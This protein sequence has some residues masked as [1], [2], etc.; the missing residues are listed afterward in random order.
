[1]KAGEVGEVG[2]KSVP[3]PSKL[4]RAAST[5]S[6]RR[7]K[8]RT[9]KMTKSMNTDPASASGDFQT[10]PPESFGAFDGAEPKSDE[11][12][13]AGVSWIEDDNNQDD[14][15]SRQLTDD[16]ISRH[17]QGIGYVDD[18]DESEDDEE[19]TLHRS[20]SRSRVSRQHSRSRGSSSDHGSSAAPPINKSFDLDITAMSSDFDV[21]EAR[22]VPGRMSIVSKANTLQV[23][24]Q[25]ENQTI[26][27]FIAVDARTQDLG[28]LAYELAKTA[29]LVADGSG[30][31][32][33]FACDGWQLSGGGMNTDV[34][35]FMESDLR[36]ETRGGSLDLG[37]KLISVGKKYALFFDPG[38]ENGDYKD[39]VI[40]GTSNFLIQGRKDGVGAAEIIA[41][42]VDTVILKDQSGASVAS[43]TTDGM[44]DAERTLLKAGAWREAPLRRII[45][46]STLAMIDNAK[47]VVIIRNLLERLRVCVATD[48]SSA[49]LVVI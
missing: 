29:A 23:T 19:A 46:L 43:S 16:E 7:T 49:K 9:R 12:K 14:D 5:S 4:S 36:P 37:P 27:R 22:L 31:R 13:E 1:V 6:R 10:V 30:Y 28:D 47:A 44:G 11:R 18:E 2:S 3:R 26:T 45:T 25:V 38:T 34:S 41:W 20:E 42:P 40:R 21:K 48:G 15:R 39:A 35:M 24:L 32:L 17:M 33:E 8:R